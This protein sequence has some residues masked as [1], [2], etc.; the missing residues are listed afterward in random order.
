VLERGRRRRRTH[1]VGAE[2]AAASRNSTLELGKMRE[3][4]DDL[5]GAG[6]GVGREIGEVAEKTAARYEVFANKYTDLIND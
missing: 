4:E 3:V 1:L 6:M 5:V 2:P